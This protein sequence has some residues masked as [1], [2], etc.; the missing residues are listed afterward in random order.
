MSYA[1]LLGTYLGDGYIVHT[2][3]GVHRL[4]VACYLMHINV[5]WWIAQAIEDVRGRRAAL[6]PRP[7]SSVIDVSSY[8]KHWPCLFPQHGPARKHKRHIALTDWQQQIV[9]AHPEHAGAA[10]RFATF[11]ARDDSDDE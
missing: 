1:Y 11:L 10:D 3:R 6:Q 9:D 5:A 8:W 4:R 7:T 2:R